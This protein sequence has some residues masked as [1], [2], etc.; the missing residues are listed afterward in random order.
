[1]A[2]CMRQ[3]EWSCRGEGIHL[4]YR[5]LVTSG[6]VK[7]REEA[8]PI[9]V[10]DVARMTAALRSTPGDDSV[11]SA[12]QT[13]S[14]T[15]EARTPSVTLDPIRGTGA[16]EDVQPQSSAVPRWN[17]EGRLATDTPVEK[18]RGFS[19]GLALQN[20]L[21]SEFATPPRRGRRKKS[22]PDIY[23]LFS[24]CLHLCCPQS[25]NQAL[26]SPEVDKWKESIAAEIHTLQNQRKCWEVVPYPQGGQQNFLRSH[27]VFKIKIKNGVVNKY[28]SRLVVDGGRQVHGID[29][30]ESFFAPVVKYILK[31]S[32]IFSYEL[33]TSNVA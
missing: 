25:Y 19:Q 23:L 20:N 5:R 14:G 10:A 28:K 9:Y 16:Q 2:S 4:A 32:I 24:L 12:I 15:P 22:K 1:M 26:K 31:G 18:S 29:Y 30:T 6:D 33:P 11:S 8:T 7:P 27:F 3:H 13:S 21:Q 17:S